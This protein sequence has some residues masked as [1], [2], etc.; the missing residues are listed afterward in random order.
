MT[1]EVDPRLHDFRNVL[2][3]I[4][5]HLRIKPTPIQYDMA[6]YIQNGP[7]RAC[8][9]AYRGAGKSWL[10]SAFAI[11]QLLLD[12]SKNILV[13]SA[14]RTRADDFSTF[15]LRIIEE[16]EVFRHLVPR[17][18]QRNS[19]IAFDVGPALAAHAPS[20]TS[21]GIN[22][23]I[24][25]QRADILI[26]DDVESLNNSLTISMRDKIS[27]ATKEF[28]A[29]L[30]PGG[31]ILI[32]GTPQSENSIYKGFP[33]RG[34]D[35]RIWP[36]RY[37]VEKAMV[38]YGDQLSPKLVE[39][40]KNDPKLEGTPTDPTRFNEME[41]LER[42]AS[43]GRTGFALQYQLD[44]SLSGADQF[45]LKLRDLVVMDLNPDQGPQKVIWAS[46]PEL[47][48]NDLPCVGFGGDRYYRPMQVQGDWVPYEGAVCAIDPAGRGRD[49]TA[50]AC[51]KMLH[52]QLF[53]TACGGFAGGYE[54][55]TMKALAAIA[56]QQKVNEILVESNFGDGMWSKMFLPFLKKVH[57]CSLSEVR[58]SAQKERRILDT[59][60]PV[61]NQH[62][63]IVD[64]QLIEDDY[65]STSHL[66][67]ERAATYQLA[68]QMTRL[69]REKSSLAQDD[70]ID[71]L[72]MAVQYWVEQM[73]QDV[74]KAMEY[75]QEEAHRLSLR[76]FMESALGKKN[77]PPQWMSV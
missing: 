21:R 54:D 58:H 14:S 13:V 4:W 56:A 75:R 74:D 32:L 40:L 68:Y 3:L 11:H 36:A 19:K 59:L 39:D 25:G 64:R 66:P 27:E 15:T 38:N 7:R 18:N 71:V 24:T 67:T 70:R 44:Q 5:E 42:E 72:S 62:R 35:L 12:P 20:V 57:P 60:E 51:V 16:M 77:G 47:A 22:S 34:Y 17:E 73:G 53:L 1:T 45:P 63:L 26:A 30:K 29:V 23:Q 65:H 69:T 33:E 2:Y 50:Y 48:W 41:L 10:C 55:E 6:D 31:R 49:E 43:Y 9:Q 61:L 46:S 76:N 52:G 8:I 37:P 28:E